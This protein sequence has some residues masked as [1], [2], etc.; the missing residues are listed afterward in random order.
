MEITK[1]AVMQ[2]ESLFGKIRK[3]V[4]GASDRSE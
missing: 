4:K 2:L 1:E 3:I